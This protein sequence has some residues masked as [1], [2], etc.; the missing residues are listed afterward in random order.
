MNAIMNDARALATLQAL[1][2]GTDPL[3]GAAFPAD[4][5]YQHPDNVRALYHAIRALEAGANRPKRPASPNQ[6]SNSGK[7]WSSREDTQLVSAFDAGQP[8]EALAVTHGRSRFAIEARL[9]KLG[10]IPMPAGVRGGRAAAP[11]AEQPA[12]AMI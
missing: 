8:M 4:S 6:P 5:P 11:G 1:A 3:T 10:K 2:N 12:A 7:P 9:A